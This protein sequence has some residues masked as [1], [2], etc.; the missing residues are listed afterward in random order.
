MVDYNYSWTLN[1][2][3]HIAKPT[4]SK[5]LSK[6]FKIK[7]DQIDVNWGPCVSDCIRIRT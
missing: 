3:K 2:I 6:L 7:L 1:V 5:L 4:D